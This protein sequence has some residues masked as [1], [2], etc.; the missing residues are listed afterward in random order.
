MKQIFTIIF[1]V[2]CAS[3]NLCSF[4][5]NGSGTEADPYQITN[6]DELQEMNDALKAYYILMNYIDARETT[7]T[8]KEFEPI[9][10]YEDGNPDT[11]FTGNFDGQGFT[12]F[13][14]NMKYRQN[15]AGFF[16]C[17]ADGA[18]VHD[19]TLKSNYARGKSGVGL[20][21]GRII[22][23]NI[24]SVVRIE[25]C[26]VSGSIDGYRSVAGFCGK[27]NAIRGHITVRNCH[28]H[29]F[30]SGIDLHEFTGGFCSSNRAK[31]PGSKAEII[32]CSSYIN[33]NH[34]LDNAG[35]FCGENIAENPESKAV[36]IDCM[37]EGMISG[38]LGI[39]GF[40]SLNSGDIINSSSSCVTFS[41]NESAGFCSH[42]SGRIHGCNSIGNTIGIQGAGGFCGYNSGIISTCTSKASARAIEGDAGGFC[43]F[44][45]GIIVSCSSSGD[46]EGKT[47]GGFC[48]TNSGTI[49]LSS[50]IGN[51]KA[52]YQGKAGGFCGLNKDDSQII[53]SYSRGL[54]TGS[55]IVSGFI[56]EISTIYV[57]NKALIQNCYSSG[58]ITSDKIA[59]GF[60]AE[61]SGLGSIEIKNCYWDTETSGIDSSD[62]GT[63]KTTAEMK[64]Q[65][66][67]ENWDFASIWKINPNVNDGYP[68]LQGSIL[69]VEEDFSSEQIKINIYPNP[70]SEQIF[71][72]ID[73][74]NEFISS[75][76]ISDLSGQMLL[77]ARSDIIDVSS[78]RSGIYFVSVKT[79]NG[80]HSC[81]LIIE[82]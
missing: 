49:N 20:F 70:A 58:A 53:N 68:V 12:I 38:I 67:Y 4:S 72:T 82:K 41:N 52:N 19:M 17:I 46:T 9:G 13:R 60:C 78:L 3:S 32:N 59:G 5:G 77:T 69:S 65:S 25:N 76:H 28:S 80:V 21:A 74:S 37:S 57:S 75:V 30:M 66:T 15:Y 56:G 29:L 47:V 40:C 81:K 34:C 6:V 55:N 39:A 43:G 63:G 50:S 1:L 26:N 36:I 61:Q 42:N 27:I 35:G 23:V 31:Y 8:G 64:T 10:T 51:I 44:N 14:V 18:Y 45:S 16:G 79:N 62:G 11:G 2:L 73:D 7:Y 54:V 48:G 33:E 22:A 24:S 71:I